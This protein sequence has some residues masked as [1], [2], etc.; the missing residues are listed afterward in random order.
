MTCDA[1]YVDA[2]QDPVD[3][4]ESETKVCSNIPSP[5]MEKFGKTCE[6]WTFGI[7]KAC[8]KIGAWKKAL[9]CEQSCYDAGVGYNSE[10]L[11]QFPVQRARLLREQGA[12]GG[13]HSDRATADTKE[14]A[15]TKEKG[16]VQT[17]RSRGKEE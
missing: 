11:N 14:Q 13:E 7:K 12:R 6:T 5:F 2:N 16:S 3:G 4:C 15:A 9:Y 17:R 8:N 10:C 1:N